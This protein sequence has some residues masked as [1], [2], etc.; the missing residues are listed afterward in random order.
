MLGLYD[1]C[2]LRCEALLE[3]RRDGGCIK[4]DYKCRAHSA[5][6]IQ[7]RSPMKIRNA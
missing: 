5:R 2:T 1:K 4:G 6:S 7:T 3:V